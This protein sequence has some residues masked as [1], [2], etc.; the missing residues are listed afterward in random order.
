MNQRRKCEETMSIFS[1]N[2]FEKKK[3]VIQR[4]MINLKSFYK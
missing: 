1:Q 3:F 4:K 2:K